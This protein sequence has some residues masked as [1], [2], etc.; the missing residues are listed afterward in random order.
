[1]WMWPRF[2]APPRSPCATVRLPENF[3]LLNFR[4]TKAEKRWYILV[5]NFSLMR[6]KQKQK[7]VLEMP[8]KKHICFCTNITCTNRNNNCKQQKKWLSLN[9]YRCLPLNSGIVL[10]FHAETCSW[11][12]DTACGSCSEFLVVKGRMAGILANCPL[13]QLEFPYVVF[14]W[15]L[16][17]P[18]QL[19]SR[20]QPW[21]KRHPACLPWWFL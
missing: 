11:E 17:I 8:T 2:P 6:Q 21:A 15:Q 3:K 5:F 20:S 9:R 16:N 7:N 1:M 14:S 18:L 19:F 10:A 12:Y 13:P 4:R